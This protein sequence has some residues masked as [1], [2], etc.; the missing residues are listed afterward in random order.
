MG[1]WLE[2]LIFGL[3]L[4]AFVLGLSS[5]IMSALPQPAGAE[6]MKTKVEYSFFGIAGIV[7]CIVC[8]YAL[9]TI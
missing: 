6:T 8:A 5:L 7:V 2:P 9:S 4:V 3:A 1:N